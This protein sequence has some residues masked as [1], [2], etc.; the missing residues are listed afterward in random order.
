MANNYPTI[1]EYNQLIQKKGGNA[2]SSLYG[3][4]LIPSR[5]APIR[6]HLFGS[7]AFAAVFK[8][9]LNGTNYAIRCFLTA[10]DETI[11][12]YKIICN[13]LKGINAPWKTECEIIENE[14]S[15]NGSSYP[16]LKMEWING[17][18]IN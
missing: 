18:L 2:F 13:Y 10:E 5:T 17:A 16:I 3:I 14:I 15:I 6:V 11:N 12:R 8:G 9:S 1:G 4:N 7:G